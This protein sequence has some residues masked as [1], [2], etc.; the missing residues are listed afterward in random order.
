MKWRQWASRQTPDLVEI[1]E[2]E[3]T[4]RCIGRAMETYLH[5]TTVMRPGADTFW[6]FTPR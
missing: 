4:A 5:P 1:Q 6:M 3:D 2:Y